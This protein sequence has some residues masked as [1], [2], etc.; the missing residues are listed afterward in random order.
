[1]PVG[2]LALMDEISLTLSLH[3]IKQTQKD[4]A[5]EGKTYLS[6]PGE[7][8]V[9]K[10]VKEFNRSGKKGKKGFY[11]YP[12]DGE[13]YLWP[14]LR[15]YFPPADKELSQQ[16]MITRMMFIQAIEAARCLEE[17]VVISV[18]DANIGS[19]FGWGFAPFKGGVLQFINDYGVDAFVEKSQELADKYGPRFIPPEILI[20]MAEEGTRFQ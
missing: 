3:I 1:M 7:N 5:Q 6:H 13:K 8:A 12:P 16:E 19:I 2:P 10:M 9:I 18:A 11:E 4:F 20:N 14:E 17:K 15:K